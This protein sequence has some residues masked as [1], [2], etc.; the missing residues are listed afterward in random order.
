MIG[1]V[2]PPDSVKLAQLVA[3][4][5]G[6]DQDLQ[7]RAYSRPE[8]AA[9]LAQEIDDACQVILFTGRVPYSLARSSASLR[10]ETQFISHSGADLYR[11]L[12]R[13][14]IDRHGV[15]PRVSVD[16]IDDVTV[17]SVFRDISLPSPTD[18]LPLADADGQL[19]IAS[20]DEIA[21]FH[22]E[23]IRE[24]SVDACLTCLAGTHEKLLAAGAPVWRVEHTRATI[25]EAMQK[26]WLS[27]ELAQS[28]STQ[29]AIVL[30]Q[31]SPTALGKLGRYERE[32]AQ[33][34]VHQGLLQQAKKV[35]GKLSV[36][37]DTT[38]LITTSRG[39]V[40]AAISRY[41]AGHASLLVPPDLGVGIRIGIGTGATY[42]LAEDNARHALKLSN[43]QGYT[44]VV[45]PD[46]SV[47]ST[48]Q[49]GNLNRLKLQET[50]PAVLDLATKMGIGPLSIWRLVHA[51]GRLDVAALTAQQLAHTYGVQQRSA[52]RLLTSLC[53]AGLA[54]EVG[55]RVGPGAGRPQTVYKVN[56]TE[57]SA[58][59]SARSPD[60]AAAPVPQ[61]T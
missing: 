32:D 55:V 20:S 46:G 42:A 28:K 37:N 19:L 4:E 48:G 34:R 47:Y 35:S 58:V 10:A 39:A 12:A 44:N 18:V 59:L 27:A 57:L 30:I 9:Q 29:L 5:E 7:V 38:F 52:R 13:I 25:R 50:T 6:H 60:E 61:P 21:A 31:P 22:L 2:G 56:L 41:R 36:V 45:F 17:Q 11:T 3:H 26:A 53:S 24:G 8:D 1:V 14:L 16:T 15:M 51:L 40:E 49:N 33:L 43:L 23:K 54:T